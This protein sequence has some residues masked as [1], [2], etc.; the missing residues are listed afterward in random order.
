MRAF[1][2]QVAALVFVG[3]MTC[4]LSANAQNR[5]RLTIYPQSLPGNEAVT[6]RIGIGYNTEG[7]AADYAALYLPY[8]RMASVA[9]TDAPD[10][11]SRNCPSVALLQKPNPKN[12]DRIE[13]YRARAALW[14]A[15][16]N[17]EGWRCVHGRVG[18]QPCLKP[19][20]F[21]NPVEG[22]EVHVWVKQHR[23]CETVVAF[24]GTDLE[25]PGDWLSNFR[26]FNWMLPIKDQYDQVGEHIGD[27]IKKGC[28]GRALVATGHSLGGGLAQHAA[29]SEKKFKYVYAF[30]PSP[31][32][33]L[34]IPRLDYFYKERKLGIDRIHERGEIL[35]TPR[36]FIEGFIN[37][38]P[39]YPF[40]RL[41]TFN[42]I[43]SG[44][45]IAQHSMTDLTAGLQQRARGGKASAA[46]G[47]KQAADCQVVPDKAW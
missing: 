8:A 9:Y 46:S 3:A 34:D 45:P 13:S 38:R 15:Q 20:Q 16:L 32:T 22:L 24:R 40:T 5:Q 43:T 29:Y 11:N 2:K 39:C 41:V 21:C 17:A 23:G 31:V 12:S 28:K 1:A 25:Q 44:S 42:E 6:V 47:L 7:R 10:L 35:A 14:V 33:G 27:I 37:P 36:F 26:W 4:S 19:S 30:D 18:P